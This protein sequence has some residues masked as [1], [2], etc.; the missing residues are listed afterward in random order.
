MVDH[1]QVLLNEASGVGLIPTRH[2]A[3]LDALLS[4]NDDLHGKVEGH[5]LRV[6]VIKEHHRGF[7]FLLLLLAVN[8]QVLASVMSASARRASP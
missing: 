5:L 4:V 2:F 3:L 7:I 1:L 8:Y 6:R